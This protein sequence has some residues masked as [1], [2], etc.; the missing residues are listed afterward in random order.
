MR[1]ESTLKSTPTFC[2]LVALCAA[3][4]GTAGCARYRIAS[5]LAN[6]VN[7]GILAIADLEAEALAAYAAVIGENYTTDLAV[8]E[9]LQYQ[10]VPRYGQFL[11]AL[12]RIQPETHDVRRLHGLYVRGAEAVLAGFKTKRRGLAIGSAALVLDGN[13]S[14]ERGR[15]ETERWRTQL[16]AYFRKYNVIY[17]KGNNA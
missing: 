5:D 9:A 12:K 2:L 7:N 8:Y 17:K 11:T 4:A 14:I 15:Q 10:V 13:A 6:Y 3:I 16:Y 1:G